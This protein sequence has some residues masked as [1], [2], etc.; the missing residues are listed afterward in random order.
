VPIDPASRLRQTGYLKD[1][2]GAGGEKVLYVNRE[3]FVYTLG[4]GPG[5]IA[6]V[7]VPYIVNHP[8]MLFL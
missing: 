2:F 6:A 5:F 7:I 3:I 4:Q 8:P 1:D